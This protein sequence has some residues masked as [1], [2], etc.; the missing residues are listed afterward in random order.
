MRGYS[1][2]SS[3]T[4]TL[5]LYKDGSRGQDGLDNAIHTDQLLRLKAWW[6]MVENASEEQREN[7]QNT[8]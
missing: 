7:I 5:V 6:K 4:L 1:D 8:M 2:R 3:P